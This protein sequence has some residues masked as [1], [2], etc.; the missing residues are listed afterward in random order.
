VKKVYAEA[1]EANGQKSKNASLQQSEREVTYKIK[2][3][4]DKNA[5]N[6]EK[7]NSMA[8]F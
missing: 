5:K 8:H 3:F 1:D 7:V 6:S 2:T 4:L